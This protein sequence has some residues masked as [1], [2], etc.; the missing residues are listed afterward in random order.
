MCSNQPWVTVNR[1][2]Q[3]LNWEKK[4]RT[5]SWR[6]LFTEA[7]LGGLSSSCQSSLNNQ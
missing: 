5:P 2:L 6:A 3:G 4:G 1:F 7:K